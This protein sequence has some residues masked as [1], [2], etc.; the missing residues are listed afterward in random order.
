MN[1]L[2][3][4]IGYRSINKFGEEL[5]G[6]MVEVVEPHDDDYVVVLADGLGSG[7]KANILSTLTSKIISTM[8]ADNM[9][10]ETCV[11]T[12]AQTLPIC[13]VRKVAY[14]TFTIVRIIDNKEAEIVQYDNPQLIL[15]RDG[16]SFA[17]PK[18]ATEIS[19]KTIYKSKISLKLGDSLIFTSDGAIYAGI[20][21]KMN[22]G[23]Q[24]DQIVEFMEEYYRPEYTAKTLTSILLD[25]CERLYGGKPGD[26]TTVCTVKI[27]ERKSVNI[28]MGPPKDPKDVNKMQALFFSKDGKHIVCGGTTSELTAKYLGKEVKTILEYLDPEIPPIAKIE[29]VD[30]TTEGVI[31]MSRVLEYAKSYLS[32]DDI[33]ADWNVRNDAASQIAKILFQEAT[34]INFFVGTAINPAHQNPKLPINFNIKMQIVEQLSEQLRNMGKRIKVSYF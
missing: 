15:L 13:N 8:I 6:D 17:Y 20:G 4:D 7:V 3:T 32:V 19:G 24:R 29:G 27:R 25:Q 11:E 10:I 28:M 34:D 26:D 21:D 23:W 2:C 1:N 14:S 33:Y 31:T 18:T 5:C 30:L 22:F 12:I 9:P 16:K